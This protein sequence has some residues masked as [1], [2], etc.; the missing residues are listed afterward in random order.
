L[1]QNIFSVGHVYH[2]LIKN[3]AL[4]TSGVKLIPSSSTNK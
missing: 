2:E 4:Y 3:A 1:T